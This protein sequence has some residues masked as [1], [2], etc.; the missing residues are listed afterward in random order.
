MLSDAGT[1]GGARGARSATPRSSSALN[2]EGRLTLRVVPDG[3]L[4]RNWFNVHVGE[5]LAKG[6]EVG[7]V[8][9]RVVAFTFRVLVAAAIVVSGRV[10]RS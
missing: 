3:R 10:G 4:E 5:E 1:R 2:M 7:R 9:A 8:D 6:F